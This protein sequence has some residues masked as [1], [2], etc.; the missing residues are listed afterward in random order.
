MDNRTE[1][2]DTVFTQ[3]DLRRHRVLAV[4]LGILLVVV[5]GVA[6]GVSA[7]VS[8]ATMI[9]IGWLMI[10]GGVIQGIHAFS[11][12]GRRHPFLQVLLATLYVIVGI[13]MVANPLA[14]EV[15]LTLMLIAFFLVA[16]ITRIIAAVREPLE[17]RSSVLAGG[18]VAVL[19]GI[20][21]WIG[22]PVSGLWAI[23]AFVGVDL[24]V[25]GWTLLM[26]G[27]AVRHAAPGEIPHAP[28][29]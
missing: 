1:R 13:L 11:R 6:L 9:F 3:E 2:P 21:L 23:G 17:N 26:L 28:S 15:G 14:A 4:V 29:A 16:G 24:I 5:G 7:A 20:F 19:L 12:E 18:I 27:I 10:I 25:G 22:W 8:L